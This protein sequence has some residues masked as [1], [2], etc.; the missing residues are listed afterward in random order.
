MLYPQICSKGRR[1]GSIYSSNSIDHSILVTE[2]VY[3]TEKFSFWAWKYTTYLMGENKRKKK[4]AEKKNLE[5]GNNFLQREIKRSMK[6]SKKNKQSKLVA[7]PKIREA[8]AFGKQLKHY[9]VIQQKQTKL[10]K[11]LKVFEDNSDQQQIT[12]IE[13]CS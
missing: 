1:T 7:M 10:S 11:A 4:R 12:K 6:R 9:V 2:V 8:K 13:K 5:K 3:P